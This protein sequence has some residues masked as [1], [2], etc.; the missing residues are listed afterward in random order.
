MLFLV[1]A[2]LLMHGV[3]VDT[4]E[5][6]G[7]ISLSHSNITISAFPTNDELTDALLPGGNSVTIYRYAYLTIKFENP[8]EI[9]FVGFNVTDAVE[10]GDVF[11]VYVSTNVSELGIRAGGFVGD[12]GWHYVEMPLL[13]GEKM[14]LKLIGVGEG[15]S[16]IDEVVI[17]PEGMVKTVYS[18]KVAGKDVPL[19][20]LIL[21][22]IICIVGCYVFER[23]GK[24]LM[25]ASLISFLLPLLIHFAG[26]ES[27]PLAYLLDERIAVLVSYL[28]YSVAIG[29]V[30]SQGGKRLQ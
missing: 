9:V 14:Y 25:T 16:R 13:E 22:F 19:G 18:I 30:Y 23:R 20:Y 12:V 24:R 6:D 29:Y 1:V 28:I 11:E 26:I 3:V 8:R 2:L 4:A 15:G 17:V 7:S 10:G 21:G 5:I 27:Y